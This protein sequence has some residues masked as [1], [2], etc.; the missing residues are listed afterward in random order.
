VTIK[1]TSVA[2]ASISASATITVSAISISVSPTAATVQVGAGNI[3]Q[4]NAAV[5]NDPLNQGVLWT[6]SPAPQSANL[7][8]QDIFDAAFNAPTTPPASDLTVTVTATS[9]SDSTKSATVTITVPSATVSITPA[10]VD[11]LEAT[12]NVP[13][14]V[15]T[16]GHDPSN[17]GVS[18][19]VSCPAEPCG[20]ISSPTSLS[21]A[22]ITYTAPAT[23]PSGDLT[24][25]VT[26]NSVADPPAQASMTVTVKAV[27]VVV[28][29]PNA[30]VLFGTTQPNIVAVVND[31]PA[32]AG[33]TWAVQCDVSP[34]G[35]LSASASASGAAVTYT[36]PTNPPVADVQVN[37][38]ATSDSDHNQQGSLQ[39]TVPA[40]TV[41]VSPVT[42]IIPVN[43]AAALNQTPFTA[44]ANND[45]SNQGVTWTMTQDTS[46][47][48]SACG[49]ISHASTASGTPTTFAAPGAVPTNPGITLTATSV[50]DGTKQTTA[51]ITLAAGTVKLIPATLPFGS[52]KVFPGT[53][54]PMKTLSETLTN[55]GNSALNI[56]SQTITAGTSSAPFVITSLCQGAGAT[57]LA[58]GSSC[59]I[60]VKFAPSSTGQFL[61]HLTI[62]DNDTTSPQQILLS[63]RGCS[64]AFPCIGGNAIQAAVAK[65]QLAA[66]PSP[67]GPYRIGT[68]VMDLIDA[69]RSDPYLANGAKRELLVRFW[70][71]AV[72]TQDCKPAQYTSPDVWNYMARLVRVSPPRVKT[73][74]CQDASIAKGPHP[75]VVVT[76]GYTG[77]FT[78]YT[79]LAED[80]ASRGYV[81]ASV[82]HTFEATA[83]QFPDGRMAKSLIGSH[84]GPAL[85]LDERSTSLAVAARLSDL[86]FLMNELARMNTSPANPFA[87]TL[88]LSRVALAGHSLGGMTALLGVEL[89]PRFRAALS[90][91]GVVPGALFGTTHKP[92]LMLF[93]GHD[94]WDQDTCHLWGQLQ[95]ERLALNFK[96]SEHLTPSDAVWLANGAVETGTMGME[97]TVAAIRHY[98]AAFLDS[99]LNGNAVGPRLVAS[100]DYPDVEVTTRTQ[101]PCGSANQSPR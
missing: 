68:R 45:S 82:N 50:A 33:V 74:S 14:I 19:S 98:V 51:T 43:A 56:T 15:A 22:A 36:A 99:N 65:N 48:S 81:V 21:G 28:T 26:A 95:G 78:D 47:C 29:A 12:L 41:S 46:A 24:V 31:D 93:A 67:T 7:S 59:V 61:A 13:N 20:S 54:P 57:N 4:M 44:T 32:N 3:V 90:I 94:P 89:E 55:A 30:T 70:Y 16:V 92:V 84:F 6:I 35:T 80:L 69:T 23:P 87:K 53:P 91:D 42:A 49:T 79:F 60:G 8:I 64:R 11:S 52:L 2:D 38:I 9:K 88:D 34:C 18:W 62:A 83:V 63:G 96:G 77:T 37:L 1:A 85:P 58:S 66:V 17:R 39:I 73:N 76:H 86:K 10:S 72:L 75:V 27:S 101:S 25:I 71:P 40:I 97:K 100:P 5:N